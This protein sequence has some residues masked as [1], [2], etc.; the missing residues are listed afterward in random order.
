MKRS[1]A[2]V[3]IAAGALIG[4]VLSV[5]PASATVPL[6]QPVDCPTALP[7]AQA[8]PGLTGTGW[9]VD[10]GTKAEPFSATVLGRVTDGVGPGVD[11]IMARLSSP[12]LTAAGGVWAGMSGSPVYTADGRLIGAVAYGLAASSPVAGITPAADLQQLLGA[13]PDDPASA[14]TARVR[15]PAGAARALRRAGV[16]QEQAARGFARLPVPLSV[17]GATSSGATSLVQRLQRRTGQRVSTGSASAYGT[18]GATAIFG[19]SNFAA[20]ASYG[21]ATLSAVGTTTFTCKGRAVAFGHPMLDAGVTTYSAHAASAVYV[22]ADPVFGPFKVAN[23][24]GVVGVVDRDRTLGIR[25][26]LGAGPRGTAITS[27]LTRVETKATRSGRTAAVY[28]PLAADA[29]AFHTLANVD[30]VMGSSASKGTARIMLTITGH[31]AGGRVFTVRHGDV[32]TAASGDDALDLQVA[33]M[34][35]DTVSALQSQEFEDVTLD[36]VQITGSVS[37]KAAGWTRPKVEVKQHGTWVSA[38]APVVAKAGSTLWTRTTLTQYRA[39]SVHSVVK[40]GL[41]V[42]KAAARHTTVLT[43]TGGGGSGIDDLIVA[44]TPAGSDLEVDVLLDPSQGGPASLDELLTELGT[45]PRHDAITA[46]LRNLVSGRVYAEHTRRAST[47][48]APV[49][50]VAPAVVS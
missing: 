33:M 32:L 22:Q 24:G 45:A 48:V 46:Q 15:P 9:T 3:T 38:S 27:R 4:S 19:G 29:A 5:A 8:V 36:T 49:T 20:A 31:R 34:V 28:A 1:A 35:Y 18:A 10:S 44:G 26:R 21:D 7:T 14:A 16:T 37:A 25:S 11:M 50:T 23:T 12:A 43:V 2:L 13:D 42:P 17:S 41:T 47:T 6:P 39:P 40:V 30:R